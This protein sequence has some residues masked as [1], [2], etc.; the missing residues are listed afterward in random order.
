MLLERE[1]AFAA[2]DAA[3]GDATRGNGAV[4]L[5]SGEA[6]I[7]KTAVVGRLAER[8]AAAARVLMAGCEA[9][10]APRPF[11]PLVDLAHLL[12]AR[13]ARALHAGEPYSGLF[14]DLLAWLRDKPT[15]LVLEDLHWADAAT[16]DLVRYVGRRLDSARVLLVVTYRDDEVTLEHPLLQVLGSLPRDR[17]RRIALA[18]LSEGAVR[19]LA[20]AAGRSAAD[21]HRVTGGNPF[22]V[23]EVLAGD[24]GSVP[25]SVRDAVLARLGKLSP[26]ARE[27]A[28][29]VSLVPQEIE[30]E[31]LAQLVALD[32][33]A[34]DET[35]TRGVLIGT[36]QALRFRHEL[37]RTCV[38]QWL[39]SER[40]AQMHAAVF[41]ALSRRPDAETMLVRRVHHAQQAGLED[42]V[43]ELAPRAARAAAKASAHRDAASLYGLVLRQ[44]T[45]LPHATLVEILEARAN[46]C[47]W[48]QALDEAAAAREQAIEL[49]RASGDRRACGWNLSRLAALRITRPEALELV[50]EAITL[51]EQ[52]EPGREL[53]WACSDMAAV[54]T[55]RARAAD[56]LQWGR[57]GLA[58]AERVGEPEVLAHT[59]NICGAVE[60]SLDYNPDGL[61]KLERSLELAQAHGLP[62]KVALAYL[63]LA[64]MA[65]VNHDYERLLGYA[66][67]GLT[68][69]AAHDLDFIV[70]ALRLRRMFGWFDLGRWREVQE[71]LDRLEAMPT[72]L[73]R[74]RNTV[75]IW[76]ARMRAL[77]GVANEAAEWREVHALGVGAQTELRPAAVAAACA[78]AA[79]LR[80]DGA[81]AERILVDALPPAIASGEPWMLGELLVWLPRCGGSPYTVDV[82]IAPLYRMELA[83]DWQGAAA[84]WNRLGCVYERALVLL[85]GDEPALR[86]A[87]GIFESIGAV[88][89]AALARRRLRERGAR[90]VRRGPYQ[91]ARV[92]PLGLTRREREVFDLVIQ[93]HSNAAIAG[94]LHRSE[95]TIEHHVAGIFDKLGV[96]SRAAL[97]AFSASL[98]K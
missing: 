40:R 94:R 43:V 93:G 75:R 58:L 74:E 23:T 44:S 45:R 47:T 14:P 21:L 98:Q 20:L 60:L 91:S 39:P 34:I 97:R 19:Q 96:T 50:T 37:A 25:P 89:I 64:G 79:W 18:P 1:S 22:F 83:G 82:E 42:A 29:W 15:L 9:L 80:D 65:L 95:R 72:L 7:G 30:R 10:N 51:L 6:G 57:R 31:L 61:A 12:P 11:G 36:A 90:G 59:L 27:I 28:L 69:A 92:D 53:A 84:A 33:A 71:E 86:E 63:N 70:A 13:V 81:A 88:P 66:E 26:T 32:A 8:C 4:V 62:H 55:A 2:L 16:L 5:V 35:Q 52:V 46:E 77:T 3:L 17:T 54:L 49:H 73:P 38:E 48:I 76:R 87:L 56:A 85:G 68:F 67:R 41:A 78:E 24:H